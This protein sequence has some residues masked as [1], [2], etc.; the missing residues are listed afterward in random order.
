[1]KIL[2]IRGKNLASLDGEFQ[3]DFNSEPLKSAGIYAITGNTGSG[4][5]TILDA[6]CLALFDDMPRNQSTESISILDT[7]DK[8]INQTDS[9]NILRKGT[10]DGYAEVDFIALDHNSYRSRW[11]VRRSRDKIDGSLQ[12]VEMR[13][14]NLS[15]NQEIPGKKKELLDQISTL[16]GFSY[17]Q[18]TRSVLLAQGDFATFLKANSKDKAELLQKLTGTEIYAKISASIHANTKQAA[19]EVNQLKEKLLGIELIPEEE[20]TFLNNEITESEDQIIS[21]KANISRLDTKVKWAIDAAAMVE[22]IN[23][24]EKEL[25]QAINYAESA[26]PR[27][28]LINRIELVQPIRDRYLL[29]KNITKDLESKKKAVLLYEQ[30]RIEKKRLLETKEKELQDSVT[31]LND[32]TIQYNQLIPLIKR[33]SEL[34]IKL[35][36]VNKRVTESLKEFNTVQ[37]SLKNCLKKQDEINTTIEKS[38]QNIEISNSWF[39]KQE[40]FKEIIPR[41]DLLRSL[42]RDTNNAFEKQSEFKEKE[43][44]NRVNINDLIAELAILEKEKQRLDQLQPIEII[45]LRKK[46]IEGEPCPVCGSIHHIVSSTSEGNIEEQKLEEEKSKVAKKIEL[47]RL[48][49]EQA[50]NSSIQNNSLI[51]T[52]T[53]SFNESMS[54]LEEMLKNYNNWQESFY[55]KKLEKIFV[56]LALKWNKNIQNLTEAEKL[57]R[58]SE[59]IRT[60]ETQNQVD[61]EQ[62][63]VEREQKYNEIKNEL[64]SLTEERSTIL[65]GKDASPIEKEFTDKIS[66]L[67]NE[68]KRIEKEKTELIA[69]AQKNQGLLD[70]GLKAIEEDEA[71]IKNIYSE[72]QSWL[73]NSIKEQVTYP[74]LE[75]LFSYSIDWIN[76]EKRDLAA[77]NDQITKCTA[78]LDERKSNYTKHLQQEAAIDQDES[79]DQ[80]KTQLNELSSSRDSK[81]ARV[82]EVKARIATHTASEK[83]YKL[84]EKELEEKSINY[85]N[86]KKLNDLLGSFDGTKFKVLAQGYTLDILLQHANKHLHE[87]SKRYHLERIPDSLGLQVQ[88]LD[89]LGEIRTVHSLSGG[90]SFL[91][92]LALALGLSSL[93][94]NR[95]R[96]ESLFIDE[97]FGSLDLDTLRTAMD[98]LESLQTM[99]RKIGVISHVS[100]MTDRITTQIRVI[101]SANGKS[102]IRIESR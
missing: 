50:N 3:I 60:L 92:S 43:A 72:L 18:F 41:I 35:K 22:T 89:M 45:N 34:D 85:D 75:Q 15:A 59:T 6:L 61:L 49:L 20:L 91:I 65:N 10:A 8:Y 27:A 11:S 98:A 32:T 54:R 12:L 70:G 38:N 9:R 78:T 77:I 57:K 62:K 52:F 86:W 23:R 16:I 63:L 47:T 83:R 13:L 30:Q 21:L 58:E 76:K 26:K 53:A 7:N 93:S 48:R 74:E 17:S 67:T 64:T 84:F 19:E 81:I 82:S 37:Q 33:A 100:E 24:A 99:G 66:F 97:G 36:E 101:K 31:T 1:M 28:A 39:V 29:S 42:I 14:T 80:L 73:E 102:Q 40:R 4:K 44:I 56:D 2:A 87:L 55:S 71:T 25:Q 51:E 94:S 68:G 96:V 95:M 90:E 79:L 88:D 5:S 69:L 46:L